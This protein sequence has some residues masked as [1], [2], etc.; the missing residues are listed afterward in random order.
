[1]QSEPEEIEAEETE[2]VVTS[3]LTNDQLEA[4]SLRELTALRIRLQR[5]IKRKD[6]AAKLRKAT[7]KQELHDMQPTRRRKKSK[8]KTAA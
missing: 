3:L 4:A 8:K 6:N 5:V 1:M 7:L 2:E